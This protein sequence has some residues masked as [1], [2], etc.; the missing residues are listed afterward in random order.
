MFSLHPGD[1][2]IGT[3]I[4]ILRHIGRQQGSQRTAGT[5]MRSYIR[6][7]HH[8]FRLFVEKRGTHGP[9]VRS[10]RFLCLRIPPF[11][12]GLPGLSGLSALPG[13]SVLR[14]LLRHFN[15]NFQLRAVETSGLSSGERKYR[16]EA[17][18]FQYRIILSLL[19]VIFSPEIKNHRT[20]RNP[21]DGLPSTELSDQYLKIATPY[22]GRS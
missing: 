20:N 22:A 19:S 17:S 1:G 7:T 8:K 12:S 6:C 4:K 15:H 13:S 5:A 11:W 16:P 2:L 9:P 3:Q 21:A 14:F 10:R 18:F